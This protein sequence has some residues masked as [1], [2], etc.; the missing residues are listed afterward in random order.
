[1]KVFFITGNRSEYG[2][3]KRLIKLVI[4]E[5]FIES[6]LFVTGDHLNSVTKTISEIKKFFS[7]AF[8]SVNHEW[9]TSCINLF[10]VWR[11]G[12]WLCAC[13]LCICV[14]SRFTV[15]IIKVGPGKNSLSGKIPSA[16]SHIPPRNPT[17]HRVP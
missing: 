12:A 17:G 2:L 14:D 10:G 16:Q 11:G 1:M 3:L 4:N 6:F 5:K 9:H 7:L 15:L 8:W 13:V